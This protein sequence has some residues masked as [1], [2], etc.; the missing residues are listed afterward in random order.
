MLP[1][2]HK[3][4]QLQVDVVLAGPG[5]EERFLDRASSPIQEARHRGRALNGDAGTEAASP[6]GSTLFDLRS[7]AVLLRSNKTGPLAAAG[8]R[9][10]QE[11]ARCQA[12][13]GSGSGT[14]APLMSNH[15]MIGNSPTRNGVAA[16]ETTS[17]YAGKTMEVT[18][19]VR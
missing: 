9:S 8:V 1:L 11:K 13:C 19:L 10:G 7:S 14:L 5:L 4:S 16:R 12:V 6:Q 3:P 15:K 2:W 18:L 17:P